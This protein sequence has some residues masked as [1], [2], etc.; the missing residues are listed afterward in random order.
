MN[1]WMSNSSHP[2][3]SHPSQPSS[4]FGAGFP[5]N[6][7][8]QQLP[9]PEG[10]RSSLGETSC[11]AES[12]WQPGYEKYQ[13]PQ[14][15]GTRRRNL[16]SRVVGSTPSALQPV[17]LCPRSVPAKP[18]GTGYGAAHCK[19]PLGTCQLRLPQPQQYGRTGPHCLQHQ[20]A[21]CPLW[22]KTNA[23]G[24]LSPIHLP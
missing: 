6:K 22:D 1:E 9:K 5:L 15:K 2:I 8:Q 11:F 14:R 13:Q 19:L 16:S 4:C 3:P 17:G 7:Q 20:R 21:P 24:P 10:T 23:N 18:L 12:C